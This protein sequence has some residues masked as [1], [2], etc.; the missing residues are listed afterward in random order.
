MRS[1]EAVVRSGEEMV[2]SG[3]EVTHLP[4][5]LI[6]IFLLSVSEIETSTGIPR[7]V[8]RRR[9]G[10][11]QSQSGGKAWSVIGREI[12]VKDTYRG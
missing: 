6:A 2:S 12:R 8:R 1:E 7:E 11:R 3:Q 9:M 5:L 10:G 4:F